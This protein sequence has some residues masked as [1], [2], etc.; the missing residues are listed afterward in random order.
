MKALI[1]VAD[2]EMKIDDVPKPKPREGWV[3]LRVSQTG[4]CGSEVSAYLGLNELRRPPLIMGH[5]FSGVVEKTVGG[6]DEMEGK[7]VAVNPLVTCGKCTFC[8]SGLRNLCPHRQIVGAAFQGS[9][10]EFVCVP[11]DSCY[12]VGNPT[13]G[14]LAE[15]LATA[16]R[17]VGKCNLAED[18]RAMVFGVGIIGL[19]ILKLLR[20]KGVKEC[21]VA[22]LNEQ[23]LRTAKA[24][25]ASHVINMSRKGAV[26]EMVKYFD[27]GVDFSFDAVGVETTRS[28]CIDVLR[29][30]GK[31][32]FIGNHENTTR[33]DG[34]T[35]VRREIAVEGS[36]AYTDR[37]FQR[38][39]KL[40]QTDFI[41]NSPEWLT[42]RS[43][44]E[45]PTIFSGLASNKISYS[46][47]I[48]KSH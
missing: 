16:M 27:G 11:A 45:G 24:S 13:D 23:R 32:V 40:A 30:G 9:F 20:Y 18:D 38:S 10:A 48:L 39:V 26:E 19:F 28:Y 15:P 22:D 25:G 12:P 42:V 8:T 17:A 37:E 35:V 1:W 21:I 29:S 6:R 31:A 47:V 43:L 33:I 36:Y 46:K 44:K 7:L 2:G 4:I 5:E 34:N 41:G 3:L 14:A